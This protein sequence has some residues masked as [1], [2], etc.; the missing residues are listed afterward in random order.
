M[1]E[2]NVLE[3]HSAC[4]WDLRQPNNNYTNHIITR[5]RYNLTWASL[6]AFPARAGTDAPSGIPP[7][8][9]HRCNPQGSSAGG[10]RSTQ[11]A[12][13][14]Q[15]QVWKGKRSSSR[16]RHT[17][18]RIKRSS[19]GTVQG[20][21]REG[22]VGTSFCT[23]LEITETGRRFLRKCMCKQ[24]LRKK[25]RYKKQTKKRTKMLD[26]NKKLKKKKKR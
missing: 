16:A 2:Q 8:W 20:G 6:V 5:H 22:G 18:E 7:C 14:R 25:W 12:H 15:T 3:T 26:G 4:C 19:S 24:F 17:D 23:M 10:Q 1:T 9:F 21:E 11:P 13:Q